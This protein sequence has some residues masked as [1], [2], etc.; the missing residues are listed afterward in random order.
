MADYKKIAESRDSVPEEN[1]K[2]AI[3][4]CRELTNEHGRQLLQVMFEL[5]AD[6]LLD[7]PVRCRLM[8]VYGNGERCIFVDGLG[9]IAKSLNALGVLEKVKKGKLK[10]AA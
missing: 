8:K 2:Q 4:V 7:P 10:K 3:S 9:R 6:K 1:I 5:G